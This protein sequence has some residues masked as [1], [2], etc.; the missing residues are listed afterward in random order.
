MS[1]AP[2]YLSLVHHPIRNKQGTIIT[3]AVTNLDVH[4]IARTSKTY[5]IEKYFIVTP[6]ES[7][8]MLTERILDYWKNVTGARL[9]PSRQEALDLVEVAVSIEQVI[10]RITEQTGKSPKLVATSASND[11]KRTSY[12]EFQDIL[13]ESK[14][15]F[16]F[17]FG[18]G[19]GLIPEI[20]DNSDYI[21]DPINGVNG[22]NHLSVRSAVAIILDRL[23]GTRN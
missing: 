20:L 23:L 18:T 12:K 6:L 13:S 15:P 11:G 14:D 19:Y 2:L 21:L 8:I 16:L 17:L 9:V 22:F 1:P 4:D 5:G 10:D 7:Q 3:T